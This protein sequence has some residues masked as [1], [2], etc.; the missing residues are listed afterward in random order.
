MSN[1][2]RIVREG[3]L[4]RVK[5]QKKRYFVLGFNKETGDAQLLYYEN[6]KKYS[7]ETVPKRVIS[8]QHCLGI[9]K[10]VHE[11][12]GNI[13][14]LYTKE[15]V[16][17][18][19]ADTDELLEDWFTDLDKLHQMEYKNLQELQYDI[20]WNVKVVS[21]GLGGL[22]NVTG[23]YKLCLKD[24][25]LYFIN[26]VSQEIVIEEKL[27]H[28]RKFGYSDNCVF[29]EFGRSTALGPGEIWMEVDD[30][31]IAQKVEDSLS[32]SVKPRSA[33][34]MIDGSG[35]NDE[36]TMD[37]N[38]DSP[39]SRR[40]TFIPNLIR[41]KKKGKDVE[42]RQH[43]NS[44]SGSSAEGSF[45]F[46]SK[47]GSC[48]QKSRNGDEEDSEERHYPK[49]TPRKKESLDLET[50]SDRVRVDEN[51]YTNIAPRPRRRSE[52]KQNI[53]DVRK[54]FVEQYQSSSLPRRSSSSS[55][56]DPA[57]R[58]SVGSENIHIDN[59]DSDREDGE[60]FLK[61]NP[62]QYE[63][64]KPPRPV[65]S[66]SSIEDVGLPAGFDPSSFDPSSSD[67][68]SY[69]PLKPPG[70]TPD[71][72]IQMTRPKAAPEKPRNSSSRSSESF[73][74]AEEGAGGQDPDVST[75]VNMK[76][77]LRHVSSSTSSDD[78]R[79]DHLNRGENTKE[80][81]NYVNMAPQSK[82]KKS[83]SQIQRHNAGAYMNVDMNRS[84]SVGSKSP[85][86]RIVPEPPTSPTNNNEKR[87][88]PS[89]YVN[90]K[91]KEPYPE[92]DANYANFTPP[93][94]KQNAEKNA[95]KLNYASVDF[96]RDSPPQED[97]PR[98]PRKSRE[99]NYSR[100]D[101][102]KST[103]LADISSTRERQFHHA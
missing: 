8:L 30:P 54:N 19:K 38:N 12:F 1:L 44:V 89:S 75:Y 101:F 52:R 69:M 94:C 49:I 64:M 102:E 82:L 27:Y 31:L 76:P 13:L 46:T 3:W 97:S 53:H 10:K 93:N 26:P 92:P 33:L 43:S 68:S 47:N 73:Q 4:K 32:R 9:T 57:W 98:R 95:R 91:T 2:S 6:P 86:F 14:A 56:S 20:V 24:N 87:E 77:G 42:G 50:R 90:V 11:K 59:Y 15:A 5:N 17:H 23:S 7:A 78:E 29:M 18:L 71:V 96:S 88:Q 79:F 67:P 62:P 28:V 34:S 41:N 72:Y 99:D 63:I 25:T 55:S 35:G 48:P 74:S 103:V 84:K 70:S 37:N 22:R 21:R 39:R 16:F 65:G 100:I 81:E 60:T 45:I 58:R 85:R 36:Q 66:D 83:Q 61:H 80:H 40:S 51:T